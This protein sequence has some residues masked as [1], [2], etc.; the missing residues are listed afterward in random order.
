[1]PFSGLHV[2]ASELDAHCAF[3]KET[4]T[5]ITLTQFVNALNGG[6]LPE[7]P[8]LMTFDDGYRSVLTLA[9]PILQRHGIPAAMFLCSGPVRDRTLFWFDSIAMTR[10]E[11]DVQVLKNASSTTWFREAAAAQTHVM[12]HEPH[13]PLTVDDIR[14][15]SA[16]GMEFGGHTV[17]HPILVRLSREDQAAE[18][19]GNAD[20]IEAWTGRRPVAFAYPNGEASDYSAETVAILEEQRFQIAFT[21]QPGFALPSERFGCRR[22][23]VLSGMSAA[24]LAHGLCYS[25]AAQSGVRL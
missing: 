11:H 17:S 18:V 16:W 1:V 19:R 22:F 8:V 20:M 21:T 5:P 4:C 12:E 13:A 2:R 23:L 6:P 9:R 14:T 7:R 24:A 15:L 25:W 10:S 3:I